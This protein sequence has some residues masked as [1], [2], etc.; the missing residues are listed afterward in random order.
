[1]FSSNLFI[2]REGDGKFGNFFITFE[3]VKI[4]IK[5]SKFDLQLFF[6]SHLLI[7]LALSCMCRKSTWHALTWIGKRRISLWE[8]FRYYLFTFSWEFWRSINWWM[9]IELEEWE[10]IWRMQIGEGICDVE[11][12]L[13][14]LGWKLVFLNLNFR[15]TLQNFEK[16]FKFW[17]FCMK[18]WDNLK[19][20]NF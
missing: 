4:D 5:T 15:K 12:I 19:T 10:R 17:F 14:I 6:N 3:G 18:I 13:M 7:I 11:E 20:I 16:Y 8:L 2:V 9:W 1:M